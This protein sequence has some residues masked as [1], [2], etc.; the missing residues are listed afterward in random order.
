MT[1]NRLHAE[2]SPYLL[3]HKDNPVH[4]QPWGEAAFEESRRSG[5]PILLSVGYAACHW[6][7]VMA[8]ESFES[9]AIADLMNDQFVNIKVDREERPDVDAIYQNALAL[10]GEH[11]G[12]P[13]TMFLN[14]RREPFWGGTYF[15]PTPRY[16]RPGFG[17]I[18]NRVAEAYRSQADA[19]SHNAEAMVKALT[20]QAR[21]AEATGLPPGIADEI[22]GRLLN[23][24]DPVNGGIG[25]APK[26]PQSPI[27]G[28]FWRAF[29]RTGD[30][31]YRHATLLTLTRMCQGGIYDHLGGGF[32]RYTV[33]EAWLVP[34]FEKMLYDNAQLLDIL[35]L[36]WQ[37]TH[38]PLFAQRIEETITWVLRE[39]VAPGGGFSSSLDA[40]S[41]GEEG[42][43]YVWSAAEIEA[44]LGADAEAFR[45]AYDVR[46]E[47]NWEGKTILNR[48]DRPDLGSPEE[49]T[50]LAASRAILFAARSDRVRPG[51]D[52][53]VLADWNGLMIAA[54][55]RA[56]AVFERPDWIAEARD[57]F[58]F[59]A[60]AMTR[61]GRLHHS[62][63]AGI[64]AHPA[65][66]DD[67]AA[68]IRAALLLHEAEAEPALV[69]Q[70]VAWARILD[71]HYWDEDAGGYFQTA[72]DTA[73]LLTRRKTAADNATPSGT[74]L[75]IEALT[76]LHHA[77]GDSRYADRADRTIHALSGEPNRNIFPLA[78]YLN[79]AAMQA[80][81]V[82]IVLAADDLK[83][84]DALALIRTAQTA[85]LP[86]PIL[87][88][89]SSPE[90]LPEGHP[91]RDRPIPDRPTAY[92]CRGTTCS[93]PITDPEALAK[94]LDA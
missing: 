82:Q 62:W 4:W 78:T 25:G 46:P 64:A 24:A 1:Q 94:A 87:Q 60:S 69:E 16:G 93:L 85:P 26:F 20:E 29:R 57:A 27:L 39:M 28:L 5:K 31:R 84:P 72:D 55:A 30:E 52:D 45:D 43:F 83:E 71:R 9:Q 2:T 50:R 51:L 88:I 59:V 13:L 65:Q 86:D 7:H 21:P 11:G 3:Q 63:R 90:T 8:H 18:L 41:E 44:L 54:M 10:L 74:G 92:V 37:A 33:D 76:R 17:D 48:T 36:G 79:A 12:W 40:D 47:G 75:V 32:S 6:C 35:T 58:R 81:G 49:E 73:D 91:A 70:A 67:Y 80:D 68:M 22:A 89:V 56:G 53:K 34:H 66:L 61:D 77:T 23:E 19:V 15:P 38:S 42:R 14:D